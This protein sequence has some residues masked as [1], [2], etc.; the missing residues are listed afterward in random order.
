MLGERPET[1]LHTPVMTNFD[2][3]IDQGVA[4]KLKSDPSTYATYAGWNFC[5]YVWWN[6]E[7]YICE[8]WQYNSLIDWATGTLE[9]IMEEVSTKYG[10]E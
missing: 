5:G 9:E 6:G 2:H 4:E 10:Y 7:S 3:S 8:V 1:Y